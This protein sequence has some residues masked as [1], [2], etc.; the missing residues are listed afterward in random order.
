MLRPAISLLA[1]LVVGCAADPADESAGGGG[2]GGKADDATTRSGALVA[3]SDAE[4]ENLR[5]S[6]AECLHLNYTRNDTYDQAVK[7]LCLPYG[8]DIAPIKMY[9]VV[10]PLGEADGAYKVLQL[11]GEYFTG[12]P[13]SVTFAMNGN[14]ATYSFKMPSLDVN[15]ADFRTIYKQL[16]TSV[17]FSGASEDPTVTGAFTLSE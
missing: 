2:A 8:G 1:V 4:V 7:L 14:K 9:M 17:T 13:E 6:D 3:L 15:D 12:P 11:E 5:A 10:T 16:T